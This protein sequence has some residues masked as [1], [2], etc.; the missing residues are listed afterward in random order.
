MVE[1]GL[2]RGYTEVVR[3]PA[4]LYSGAGRRPF[5]L[6]SALLSLAMLHGVA[7]AEDWPAW[8]HDAGR[9]AC[10][11][12][13][14]PAELHLQWTRKY[15]PL[16]PA[17]PGASRLR[18]DTGYRPIA[19]AGML[20]VSSSRND[21]VTALDAVTGAEKWRFYAG[22]PVRFAPCY[23]KGGI[24]FTSDDGYLYCVSA[25]NG[26]LLW[27]YAGAPLAGRK[28][29]GNGR[30]IST[31]PARGAPVIY[32]GKVY[33]AAGIWPFMGV[34]IHAVDAVSGKREW[35]NSGTGSIFAIQPHRSPAFAGLAPQGYLAVNRDRLLVPNGRAV[36]ACLR[37]RNGELLYFH[38]GA[39]NSNG[40]YFLATR[41]DVFF[42]SYKKF[43]LSDGGSL[44]YHMSSPVLAD[45]VGY[46]SEP[47]R[48]PLPGGPPRPR[49]T[50]RWY[51]RGDGGL[52]Q[53]G[54]RGDGAPH[55]WMKA[56]SRL[57]ATGGG[58]VMA[59]KL[60]TRNGSRPEI[61]W[62]AKFEGRP[63]S[64]LAA[65]GR[66]FLVTLEGRILCFGA[67][68]VKPRTHVYATEQ[69]E[70]H[71]RWTEFAAAAFKA[72]VPRTGY[73]VLFGRDAARVLEELADESALETIAL[74][75]DAGEAAR[76]RRALDGRGLYG[77]RA[78]I[79][80]DGPELRLP[81]YF[82][83][84]AIYTGKAVLEENAAKKVARVFRVLRPYGGTACFPISEHDQLKRTVAALKLHGAEVR[85][86]GRFSLLIRKGQLAGAGSWT[87]QYGNP[88][89]TVASRD[90]RVKAPLGLL[91]FGG[92]SNTKILPRHGH[93]PNPQV[94]GGRVVIEGPDILRALDVY[95]GALLWEASLPG[96]GKAYDSTRHQP[97]A[98]ALGSNYVTLSDAVYVVY[99]GRCLK[100]DAASGKRLKEFKLPDDPATGEKATGWGYI[101]VYGDLLLAGASPENLYEPDYSPQG[102]KRY[103]RDMDELDTMVDWMRKIKR[104]D[105]PVKK[106]DEKRS[107]YVAK[108]L[109]RLLGLK[110][111]ALRLP[112]EADVN[113]EAIATR[114]KLY[115]RAKPGVTAGDVRLRELNRALI[116]A[117]NRTIPGRERRAAG[118][119]SYDGVS[120]RR[121][122]AMDRNSGEVKWQIKARH[123][124]VHNAICAG[125]GRVY[126]VD[127]LPP[128]MAATHRFTARKLPKARL[129][130]LDA[131]SGRTVWQREEE[132]FAPFLSY[133]Q[134]HDVLLQAS[135]PSRDHLL[136]TDRRM[137]AHRG[138]DGKVLWR[139][140]L[141]YR[142]PPMLIG[143]RIITQRGALQLLSGKTAQRRSHLTGLSST[144]RYRRMYGCNSV[145]GSTNLIT[146]RSAAAGFY[147][148]LRDGGTGN[149]GGFKS[150]CSSNLII[151]DGVLAAPDYTRTCKCSYHNQS[152]LAVMHDPD[153]DIWTFNDWRWSGKAVK[154]VG[155]NFGA[156]GD[157]V[158]DSGTI[159]L[160][161]PSL[162]F[163][164]PD[165]P[166]KTAPLK[167]LPRDVIWPYA[168]RR[169]AVAED[170][171]RKAY[172][173]FFRMHSTAV[174]GKGL[175]WV[176]ASG[177][178]NVTRIEIDLGAGRRRK[179]T[180]RLHFMEPEDL[181]AGRRLF[182][183]VIQ[184]RRL[185]RGLDIAREA[186]GARKLLVREIKGVRVRDKLVL[187]FKPRKRG[188]GA[189]ISGIEAISEEK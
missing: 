183:V 65:N 127:R 28:V 163:R 167:L 47:L 83:S 42:N 49:V 148:L 5:F 86:A 126:C 40:K 103:I 131:E 149:I 12:E 93:G 64:L 91:W 137:I 140:E 187:E 61:T 128:L 169:R 59:L 79:L 185:I 37:R 21:S 24:Y 27:K 152:S 51:R 142:G 106:Q 182:D 73:C 124:F 6:V 54:L 157:R 72:G 67:K 172:P 118:S 115:V 7:R 171:E 173:E 138:R 132:V 45:G 35:S 33:F 8:R 70:R 161:W 162:G 145:V 135:R 84:L 16:R 122:V 139:T 80:R 154:K 98:N 117:A 26:R 38:L 111:L 121:L 66:L 75:T 46:H 25:R 15:P 174:Q 153:A 23:W 43:R 100:L 184:D 3:E 74:V 125:G 108:N 180:L 14:L 82:A 129:M 77:Q 63:C 186:G 130:A 143:D 56:G 18:F 164:S 9:T 176:A 11:A 189:V 94:A 96:V 69:I 150:G 116:H 71:G 177:L 120:S 95:T 85:K 168:G 166:I 17:W 119:W 114:I 109:N 50:L 89:N 141:N 123:A 133:S 151:A 178:R 87:H 110:D 155:I 181:A 81:P 60:P 41:G 53:F 34:F 1:S 92:P 68:K 113:T 20:F 29:F 2:V 78:M 104:F 112:G 36:A 160:D 48:P 136:E 13:E 159:W 144:W 62:Q 4:W 88:A 102:I 99:R 76:A 90:R 179:Y 55:I 10:T 39:N 107:H 22:G 165:L 175:K 31:W 146:F 57:Y 158:S 19:A 30:L 58:K 52:T 97:G 105:L 134:K 188:Y 156:P 44:G 170:F 147:D 101:A 32:D